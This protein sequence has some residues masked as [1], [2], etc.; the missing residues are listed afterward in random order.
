MERCAV[1]EAAGLESENATVRANDAAN[2]H[3]QDHG[4]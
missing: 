2:G 1:G 4:R 3:C